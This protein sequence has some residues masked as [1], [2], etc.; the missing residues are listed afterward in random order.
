MAKQQSKLMAL[1]SR[2]LEAEAAAQPKKK[3]RYQ[4]DRGLLWFSNQLEEAVRKNAADNPHISSGI[5]SFH[6][7][8]MGNPCDRYLWLH[9]HRLLPEEDINGTK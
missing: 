1:L 4:R 2:D 3:T 8:A 7:S 5:R 9:W 6:S